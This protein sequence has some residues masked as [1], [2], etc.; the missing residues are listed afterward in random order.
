MQC[1]E[2][3]ANHSQALLPRHLGFSTPT[4]RLSDQLKSRSAD[5]QD[6]SRDVQEADTVFAVNQNSTNV[7]NLC[8]NP[9]VAVFDLKKD[10]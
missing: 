7:T 5:V 6:I 10:R 1:P 8:V 2:K 4:Q 9:S 3:I